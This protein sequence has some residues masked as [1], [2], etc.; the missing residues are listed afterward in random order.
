[1]EKAK[2]YESFDQVLR[3]FLEKENVKEK[4][5]HS[6]D[7]WWASDLGLCKRKQFFRRMNIIPSEKKEWRF[8]FVAEDGKAGHEWREKAAEKMG[9][10]IAKEGRLISKKYRYRGRFDLI[11]KINGKPVLID[12]KTQRPEAFF[13]RKSKPQEKQV[14]EFQ[15]LQLAS[16]VLFARS[17]FPKLKI[18]EARIYYVDRGGGLRDEFV[19]H[20]KKN[21]FQKVLNELNTL[22]NLWKQKKLPPVLKENKWQCKFCPWATI[23]K[24]VEKNKLDFKKIKQLYG[25]KEKK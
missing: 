16:Y 3:A 15:K 20:F 2:N 5:E 14:E 24:K 23:C 19:F 25:S 21:V 18:K 8:M 17:E 22:N 6:N 11:V 10:L 1:M 4:K 7:W 12:I 9:V 13:R